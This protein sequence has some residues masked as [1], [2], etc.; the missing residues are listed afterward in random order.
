MILV[1]AEGAGETVV[2]L[3]INIKVW[4]LAPCPCHHQVIAAPRSLMQ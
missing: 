4:A 3:A 2:I 1:V